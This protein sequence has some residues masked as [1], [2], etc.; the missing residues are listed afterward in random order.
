MFYETFL[1]YFV[2]GYFVKPGL[3]IIL[4]LQCYANCVSRQIVLLS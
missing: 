2:I 3:H 4:Q 1:E